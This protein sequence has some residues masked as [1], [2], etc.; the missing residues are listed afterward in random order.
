MIDARWQG[1]IS[2][3]K[4]FIDY[5]LKHLQSEAIEDEIEQIKV[6]TKALFKSKKRL[7]RM[8]VGETKSVKRRLR[9]W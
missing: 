7:T 4:E 6:N 1:A 3:D 8:L 2:L 9:F 5:T